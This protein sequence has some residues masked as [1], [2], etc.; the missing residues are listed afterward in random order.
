MGKANGFEVLCQRAT[1]ENWC[2]KIFCGTCR[3]A[4]FRCGFVELAEGKHPEDP[5]WLSGTANHREMFR[6]L[7]DRSE[8]ALR[9]PVRLRGLSGVLADA[10]I[11]RI[12]SGCKF[13]DWLGYLGLALFHTESVERTDL[14]LTR[15]WVPQLI[16]VAGERTPGRAH[17][18]ARGLLTWRDLETVEGDLGSRRVDPGSSASDCAARA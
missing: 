2:W 3:H 8:L 17:L 1:Q 12:S 13:P 5:G 14:T 7:F 4:Y 18:G 9:D 10:S 6:T 11:G 16:A 15:A